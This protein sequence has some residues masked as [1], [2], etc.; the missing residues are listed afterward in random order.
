MVMGK[1]KKRTNTEVVKA[2]KRAHPLE[3]AYQ[4]T[5]DNAKRRG[6]EFTLT[7]EQFKRFCRKTNYI[8]GK[9]RTKTSYSIDRIE[10]HKGYTINNIQILPLSEN[11]KKGCKVLEYDWRTRTATVTHYEKSSDFLFGNDK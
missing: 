4:T 6:K 2:W 8:T 3:Y 10:N 1:K 5:K 11:S 7:L 9:G